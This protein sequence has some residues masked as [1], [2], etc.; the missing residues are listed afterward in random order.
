MEERVTARGSTTLLGPI[1][2]SAVLAYGIPDMVT[3]KYKEVIE[4]LAP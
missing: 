2:P 3:E 4:I 1:D